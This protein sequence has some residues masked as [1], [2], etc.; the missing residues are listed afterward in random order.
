MESTDLLITV[1][2]I[3]EGKKKKKDESLESLRKLNCTEPN[4]FLCPNKALKSGSAAKG[5]L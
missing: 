4:L 3:K 2:L 1:F 5:R